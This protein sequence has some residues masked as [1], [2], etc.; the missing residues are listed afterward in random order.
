MKNKERTQWS[1]EACQRLQTTT[2]FFTFS[3]LSRK[4]LFSFQFEVEKIS[5]TTLSWWCC[6]DV[7]CRFY[8]IFEGP[9]DS[10]VVVISRAK[11]CWF[12]S[13]ILLIFKPLIFS[14]SLTPFL[15]QKKYKK[16]FSADR[17]LM[18]SSISFIFFSSFGGFFLRQSIL[19]FLFY[20]TFRGITKIII[21]VF[22]PFF[23]T[24]NSCGRIATCLEGKFIS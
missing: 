16:T 17:V 21:F 8:L 20:F 1:S 15:P 14:S 9:V 2:F 10:F 3:L 12:Y 22:F 6:E 7:S 19:I 24:L 18:L 13:T 5:L 23:I 11:K 4:S